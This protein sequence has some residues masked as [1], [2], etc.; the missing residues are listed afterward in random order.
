VGVDAGREFAFSLCGCEPVLEGPEVG[1]AQ[2]AQERLD[3]GV[4]DGDVRGGDDGQ[5]SGR[6]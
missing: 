4:L 1:I 5:A 3:A 6:V 2:V